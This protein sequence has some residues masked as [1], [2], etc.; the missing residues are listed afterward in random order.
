M[1]DYFKISIAFL[2]PP[3]FL[4]FSAFFIQILQDSDKIG[5]NED[6]FDKIKDFDSSN[7]Y[8]YNPILL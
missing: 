1:I 7:T 4:A 8:F 5:N 3:Y 6:L 2:I